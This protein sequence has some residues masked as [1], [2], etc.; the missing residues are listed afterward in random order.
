MTS[1]RQ[2]GVAE[3]SLAPLDAAI[4]A[5]G[6]LDTEAGR[7]AMH[8]RMDAGGAS[9]SR[10]AARDVAILLAL[11]APADGAVQAFL[12][13]NPPQGGVSADP[14]AMLALASAVERRADAEAALLAVI[15]AGE[16]GA[17]RLDADSLDRLIRGLRAVG[18][19]QDARRFAAEALLAGAPG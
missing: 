5:L 17:A 7:A 11:G 15:A 19:E 18:L 9:L 4:A 10:A 13:A 14:G 8:R 6:D 1:A 12:L 16:G 3:A 2:A